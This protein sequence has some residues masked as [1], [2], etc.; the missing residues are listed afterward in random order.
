MDQFPDL[1]VEM[2]LGTQGIQASNQ[3]WSETKSQKASVKPKPL[4]RQHGDRVAG[5]GD[6]S[7]FP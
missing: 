3:E 2:P 7:F 1:R 4:D 5:G 6:G